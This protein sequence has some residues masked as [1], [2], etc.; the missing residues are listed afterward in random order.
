TTLRLKSRIPS[1]IR[2]IS[3]SGIRNSRD[4]HLLREAGV[5][6]VLVGEVLMREPNPA[7]KIRELLSL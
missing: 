4:I 6:G 7:A 2:V 1:G 5:D 3:E